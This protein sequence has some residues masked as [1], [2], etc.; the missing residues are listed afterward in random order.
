MEEYGFPGSRSILVV[1]DDSASRALIAEALMERGYR[2]TRESESGTEAMETIRQHRFDLVISDLKMPGMSG[3]DLL[4]QIQELETPPPVIIVTAYPTTDVTVSAM[5]EGAVDFLAKPFRIED[6][7]FKVNLCLRENTLLTEEEYRNRNASWKLNEKIRELSTF[8]LISERIEKTR[9]GDADIF[10]NIVTVALDLTSG[11][12]CLV[13][14]Y[15]EPNDLFYNKILRSRNADSAVAGNGVEVTKKLQPLLAKV[16]ARHETLL[17]NENQGHAFPGSCMA[18]P[19]L[20]RN[21]IF[22][23]LAVISENGNVIFTRKD[24]SNIQNLAERAS[25]YLENTILYESL[26]SSIM[27][28]FQSLVHSIHARDNYTERHSR[29]VTEL[30]L[31]TARVAGCSDYEIESLRIAGHLHDIGKIA[32]PDN[33]LL[34]PGRLTDEEYSIITTHSSI[35][36]GILKSIALFDQERI[37]VRHHHERW[38]GHGYPDG[39]GNNSIPFLARILSVADT[40]DAMTS[41]RPYRKGLPISTAVEELVRNRW[42]QFDGD[43][44]DAFLSAMDSTAQPHS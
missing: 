28:T 37:I 36:E 12:H 1:D 42:K 25:L 19:L 6:L 13:V 20:I 22:G 16:A 10:E 38:D 17:F 39:I 14:L 44:V 40:F 30:A 15:D 35:G 43:V 34:K 2:D 24:L 41:D 26:F 31:M 33:I 8:N 23:I 32:V 7:L 5:K 3:L 9:G 4:N 18:V 11:E 21:K 27:N 29:S